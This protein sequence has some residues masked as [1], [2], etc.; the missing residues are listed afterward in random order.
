MVVWQTSEEVARIRRGRKYRAALWLVRFNVIPLAVW[1]WLSTWEPPAP[2]ALLITVWLVL[3][4]T[5]GLALFLL[6]K[7]G[8][9]V[10]PRRPKWYHTDS[11]VVAHLYRDVFW[12]RRP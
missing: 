7:A 4:G 11:P 10:R 9:W 2:G 3:G 6:Y 8:V 1:L 5:A 12:Y